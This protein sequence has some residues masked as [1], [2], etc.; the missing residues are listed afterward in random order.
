MTRSLLVWWCARTVAQFSSQA[1]AGRHLCAPPLTPAY[2]YVL[3]LSGSFLGPADHTRL[4][5]DTMSQNLARS[6]GTLDRP[7]L[8]VAVGIVIAAMV[9]MSALASSADAAPK[10]VG[11]FIGG[12][13]GAGAGEFVFPRD[14]AVYEGTDGDPV[15]DKIFVV[16]G[17]GVDR[18]RV[19]RLDRSGNF[20]L[21]WGKDVDGSNQETGAEICVV[22]ST[23]LQGTV[24]SAAVTGSL[25][26]EF[27]DPTGIAVDQQNGWVYVY[28]RDN[29]R[30]QKYDV[31]GNF[32]LMFGA[33]VNTG[34]SGGPD[35]CTNQGAP[36]QVCG[37]GT[38]GPSIGQIGPS[39][40]TT[41]QVRGLAVDPTSGDVFVA[42]P[43]NQR[44]QRFNADGTPDASPAFGGATDFGANQPL[45]IAVDSNGIVYA[46][47][48]NPTTSTQRVQRYDTG[49]A[50]FLSPIDSPPL[51]S[52]GVTPTV[53]LEV[54]P[55]T[56]GAGGDEEHLLVARDP[57]AGDTVVQEFDIPDTPSDP[58]T[59]QVADSPHTY[60]AVPA[61]GI[62]VSGGSDTIY[63]AVTHNPPPNG[64]GQGVVMLT[65][66]GGALAATGTSPA[67]D[68]SATSASLS[69][70][71]DLNGWASYHFELARNG[72]DF[73]PATPRRFATGGTGFPVSASISGLDPNTTY[74]ARIVVH[75]YVGFPNQ[76]TSVS[77]N[78]VIFLTD[79]A[80]PDASTLTASNVT[81]ST[82][83]LVGRVN[84]RG[85]DTTF[86]FQYGASPAYGGVVPAQPGPVGSAQ[87]DEIVSAQVE[88][89]L[90]GTSYHYRVCA[91]NA[92]GTVCGADRVVATKED[93][94][95][96]P[97]SPGRT[98]ELVSPADKLSG[99]GVG[100]WYNGPA[101]SGLSGNAAL[102]KE[103]FAV[104]GYLGSTLLDSAFG[105]GTDRAL[106]ERVDD[107]RGWVSHSPFTRG[108]YGAQAY[109]LASISAASRSFDLLSWTS[110][111]V[112]R[113][114]P[115][116][117][118]W[119]GA[120]SEV[121]FVSDW[122]GAW[123]IVAPTDPAQV[124]NPNGIRDI[125]QVQA[126]DVPITAFST[127][128]VRGLAGSADP[129]V[130]LGDFGSIGPAGD[131][132]AVY[133][134]DLSGGVSDTFP[135]T[136][137]RSVVSVCTGAAGAGR[138]TVPERLAN[139]KLGAREC[140]PPA[141]NRSDRLVSERGAALPD[142]SLGNE[143]SANGARVF[144]LSPDPS[145]TGAGQSTCDA[146]TSGPA[147]R[148]PAQLYVRQRN[149]DGSVVTRW[150]SRSAVSPENGA[151][152]AQDAS[153]SGRVFF[154]Y[155]SDDGDRVFFRTQMPLTPD[156]PDGAGPS[157]EGGVTS[158][159]P[160]GA[161]NDSWDLYMYDLP[162]G[163]DGDPATAD[164]D[165]AGGRL[166]RV[167]GGPD[168]GSDCNVRNDGN[169]TGALRF[170]S[171]DGGR[172]YFT[173]AAPLQG[174]PG[175]SNGTITEPGGSATDATSANLYLYEDDASAWRF[176]ARLPR[177]TASTSVNTCATT[178]RGAGWPLSVSATT[179]T[180]GINRA[181]CVRGNST[182]TFV[183]FASLGR[184]MV[185]DPDSVTADIYG[186]DSV[187][188]ELSRLTAPQGGSGGSYGCN[189]TPPVVQCFGDGGFGPGAGIAAY[190]LAALGVATDPVVPSDKIAYFQSKSRLVP[191]D[192]DDA[193]DVY[194]WRNGELSLIS[195]GR[196]ATDGAFYRGN[197]ESG[198]NVYMAT[199]D[200]LS[201]QDV[202]AALDVYTAR[203][204]EGVVRPPA[205][206]LCQVLAGPSCQDV[207]GA[208]A[209][210]GVRSDV[211]S[212]GNESLRRTRLTVRRPSAR[213]RVRAA[214]RGVL[215][216]RVSLDR[217]GTVRGVVRS[218]RGG[219]LRTVAKG[220]VRVRARGVAVLRLRLDR[221][222]RRA[223]AAGRRLRLSCVVRSAGARKRVVNL[224]LERGAS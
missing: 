1:Q 140:D 2:D 48:S 55:D 6:Q 66:A 153:L 155:A 82:G 19:Q 58:I 8:G 75:R 190:P 92:V 44:V 119:S 169:T 221:R 42:D 107:T 51:L 67:Q 59:D 186:F 131:P 105:F 154:E 106:S 102:R 90:A 50:V 97:P 118:N 65:Q 216:L 103:R 178:A 43:A 86:Q 167:S 95:G 24:G 151:S 191:E 77:S 12:P 60:A 207:G 104:Q 133:I 166:V 217:A 129:T 113:L 170:A 29:N 208:L 222:A 136:G 141:P 179:T 212:S 125:R 41:L 138:T 88:G 159:T 110:A 164:A 181:G 36:G 21:M 130:D 201:W 33:G 120:L 52:S 54:D 4:M 13:S 10:A 83:R 27:D 94:D 5:G 176:V 195:T 149:T 189:T 56:D 168:G 23:C 80:A 219:R 45:H 150:I 205:P 204:G 142:E 25:A 38:G 185:D 211:L 111:G 143:V 121:Q 81:L 145:V 91:T 72:G 128:H 53:G 193:Y 175:S 69:G 78:E 137:V 194:Q 187:A 202:D 100:T 144:F 196:S 147:T 99:T 135:G 112:L 210:P 171:R 220:S 213:A 68:V 174:V 209:A 32:L 34:S 37:R 101:T 192:Q 20:E 218:G 123:E 182:G 89:L 152:E 115:E 200:R 214:R 49:A 183:T 70:T 62:G 98:Y 139:G 108:G 188:G 35:I 3:I 163:P 184:L 57:G 46:S 30:V 61:N 177:S 40:A 124:V 132:R 161:G 162:D 18:A 160:G 76:V 74:A 223:L 206:V 85:S 39:G 117:E 87:T 7:W 28:D 31:D 79:P 47:D 146:T 134:D 148:C 198:R 203:V 73:M 109:R 16:E 114:F 116:M 26:G 63:L 93:D 14:V 172:A 71:V 156:D 9:V 11:G 224:K 64:P 15:T 173:C 22:A 180:V 17:S 158:G 127:A 157:P 126:A 199:L 215:P 165:P 122:R 96:D 197:D 84:P